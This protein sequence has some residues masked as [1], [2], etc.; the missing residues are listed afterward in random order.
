MK[1]NLYFHSVMSRRNVIKD[2]IF[3]FFLGICSWPR[4]VL[5]VPF[6]RKNMGERY[7]TLA[8]AISVGVLLIVIPFVGN[9]GRYSPSVFDIITD[10]WLWYGFVAAFG[11]FSC[12]RYKEVKR[13]PSVFDFERYSLSE[14]EMLPWFNNLGFQLRFTEIFIEPLAGVVPG[15]LLLLFGQSLLGGMLT[16]CGIIYSISKAGAWYQG[17]HFVMDKIDEMICNEE[18]R[19]SL[20]DNEE[21]ARGTTFR[22]KFPD[23]QELREQL[24]GAIIVTADEPAEAF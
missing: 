3:K 9:I 12:L 20:V 23:K 13:Q 14:G 24:A 4:L 15:I 11:Y 19:K 8:S 10:N 21:P 17:D 5:E 22:S 2:V 7:F 18:L 6:L 16:A 1:K